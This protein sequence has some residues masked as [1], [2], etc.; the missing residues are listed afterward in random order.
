[1]REA[2]PSDFELEPARHGNS[3][4]VAFVR[5]GDDGLVLKHAAE[6][7]YAQWLRIEGEVLQALA[8]TELPVPIVI[9]LEPGPDDVWLLLSRLPGDP[10]CE[11]LERTEVEHRRGLLRQTGALLGRIHTAAVPASLLRRDSTPWWRRP[12]VDVPSTSSGE[13][14][15]A[16]RLEGTQPPAVFVHGDF[17]LDNVLADPTPSGVVD[18]GGAGM[19]DPRYDLALALLSAGGGDRLPPAA[20]VRA[21]Y[22]GYLETVATVPELHDAIARTITTKGDPSQR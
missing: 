10:L 5:G 14:L 3:A 4:T 2:L 19:G 6:P 15:G 12:R 20:E 9:A 11:V 1:M 21:F 17:T 7:P 16:T 22:E 8:S 18:W 13:V